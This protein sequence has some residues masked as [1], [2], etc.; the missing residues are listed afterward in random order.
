M[1]NGQGGRRAPRQ[2]VTKLTVA[3]VHA[4]DKDDLLASLSIAQSHC[5]SLLLKPFCLF[6]HA[7]AFYRREY[8]N[9]DDLA[10]DVLRARVFYYERGYRATTVDTI[11]T[12]TGDNKVAVTLRIHEG[13]PTNV[14]AIAIGEQGILTRESSILKRK[15]IAAAVRIQ[16][17]Q[18]LDLLRVDSTRAL[19][20]AKLWDHGY[21]DA[22]VDTSIRVDTIARQA[23]V[24]FSI[25]P[26]P[27][28]HVASVQVD[29]L[30]HIEESTILQSLSFAPGDIFRRSAVL[31][32]QRTLYESNLFRRAE[33]DVTNPKDS[34]KQVRITVREA[35]PREM[36]Y[37][38]GFNTVDF[39]QAE[40]RYTNY[41]WFGKARR[42]TAQLTVG[43][44]LARQLNGNG[45]FYD[46]T[47]L[48]D[49]ASESKYFL[50]TFTA[51]VES[52]RPW[53]L[54][55]DNEIAIGLFAHRR[56]SP[57]IYVDRGYGASATFTRRLAPRTP[58]SVNYRYELTGVDAS[59]VYF[60]V[61]FGVCDSP[62][63]ASF[64][65]YQQ[66]SP[67]ALSVSRDRTDNPFEPRAGTRGQIDAE[68]AESWTA[69]NFR[70]GR[71]A[72]DV[73][74]FLPIGRKSTIGVHLKLGY[75]KAFAGTAHALGVADSLG[76]ELLH[77]RKRFYSGG[78][79]SVRGFG[80]AQL[81]PRVLTIP[82]SKLRSDSIG[83]PATVALADCQPDAGV[84]E[85][86]DFVPRPLGGNI[87][88]EMSVEYRFPIPIIDDLLGAVF[89][90][91]GYL[92]QK[93]A[94][95]LPESQ[96]AITPGFGVRYASPVGPIRVD[97]GINP[98]RTE[99]LAVVTEDPV[100]HQLIPLNNSRTYAQAKPGFSGFISRLNLHLSIGEAF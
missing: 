8:L 63:L 71:I 77:P 58:L 47:T 27:L 12:P 48:A 36:R 60:C 49:S 73:A 6:S 55:P 96:S 89:V 30:E 82:A 61:N 39:V 98:T 50:P 74:G 4:L 34:L 83:C 57:G 3:G 11:V 18:P 97:V 92:A 99:K 17:G 79:Q 10:R 87:L 85:D 43:N 32:S 68:I 90:D 22:V 53:W 80:E 42:F 20:E 5:V 94:K 16:Q 64:H 35:P 23:N 72:A 14:Q 56:S 66:L 45:I 46:M 31:T 95:N 1:A 81:G 70:Y 15:E 13:P 40:G 76:S 29:G 2:E 84:L 88:A 86:R 44:L 62:T 41:N 91:A 7:P 25:R 65:K 19:L 54:S 75:I 59:D 21:A 100:T 9:H 67:L 33:I 69:S 38:V 78:S 51:S 52:R 26:G 28:A 93:T 24:R 37:S